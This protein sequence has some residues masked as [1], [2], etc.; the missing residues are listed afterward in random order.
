MITL[1]GSKW[2]KLAAVLCLTGSVL[3]CGCSVNE[4]K[5]V[6]LERIQVLTEV[7]D[8]QVDTEA[9]AESESLEAVTQIPEETQEEPP[10]TVRLI[11][12]GDML[13]HEGVMNSGLKEDG[14]YQYDH[15]FA[16]ILD[17]I[18]AADI[19][20]VNQ[21]TILGGTE[22]GLSGYPSFNSPKEV[23]KAEAE[24]GFNVILFGTNHALDKG[25]KGISNTIDYL[26]TNYPEVTYLGINKSQEAQDNNIY[27]YEKDDL[28]IAILNYTYGTNGISPPADMPYL[29][30]YLNEDKVTADIAKAHELADFVVVC[31]HWGTEYNLGTDSYQQKWTQIFLENGVD[32]VIGAHPHVIEPIEWVSDDEGH[33]MLVYYSLGNFV[34]GT[35]S[36]GTGV[37]K[38][39]VAG[40]ADVTI[41]IDEEGEA[42]IVESDVVPLICHVGIK[43]EYTVYPLEEY[44]QELAVTN[45][46]LN[47]DSNFS[48]QYCKDL[49]EEVWGKSYP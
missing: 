42:V 18:Q 41:G 12:I 33:E 26:E 3:L 31:P 5:P 34:T 7:T 30:N 32:L 40:M 45:R 9:V 14:S 15:L 11:M 28:S 44:T 1:R 19:A 6:V 27:V 4:D 35:A 48:L 47:N 22:L 36:T 8:T 17:N 16:N 2:I 20:I 38:R 25:A 46:V 49:V 10:T 23:G 24:A 13:M 43:E 39:V 29:V 21:E 37:A